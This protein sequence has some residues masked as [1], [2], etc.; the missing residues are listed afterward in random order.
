[1]KKIYT[2]D[3][4]I[5]NKETEV[6]PRRS[7]S[8]IDDL[9]ALYGIYETAW[10]WKPEANDIFVVFNITEE[11]DGVPVKVSAKVECYIVWDKGNPKATNP[12]NRTEKPNLAVSMRGMYWYIKSHLQ[13]SYTQGSSKAI[14]FL[15]NLNM[16]SGKTFEQ[17][18]LPQIVA[19]NSQF[20]LE[21]Q[22]NDWQ[23]PEVKP[24]PQRNKLG[25]TD[26]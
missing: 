18:I 11:I 10:H 2:D 17:V 23:K 22:S 3:P 20:A 25:E 5:F 24:I 6:N 4:L 9:L 19:P 26:L 8:Q 7:R 15:P 14:A 12:A 13:A 1:M 21:D 16:A